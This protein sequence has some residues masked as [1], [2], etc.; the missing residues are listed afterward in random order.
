MENTKF[1]IK[2]NTEKPVRIETHVTTLSTIREVPLEAVAD[3]IQAFQALPGSPLA[4]TFAGLITVYAV[5]D[6]EETTLEDDFPLVELYSGKTKEDPLIIKANGGYKPYPKLAE[7]NGNRNLTEFW[8]S[9]RDLTIPKEGDLK[10]ILSFP[11]IP[12]F[13]P[14][15]FKE[16]YVRQSYKDLFAKILDFEN[17]DLIRMAI[18]GNPGIGKSIFLFYMLWRL[19]SMHTTETVILNRAKDNGMIYVFRNDGCFVTRKVTVICDYLNEK[20]TWYLTDALVIQPGELQAKTILISLPD[21]NQFKTFLKYSATDILRFMPVWSLD[22][23]QA[24]RKLYGMSEKDVI[25]RYCIVGGLPRFVLE[26][27]NQDL[28]TLIKSIKDSYFNGL[29]ELRF[30]DW[31]KIGYYIDR[32]VQFIVDPVNFEDC[33]LQFSSQYVK[34]VAL[35]RL[36][37]TTLRVQN[38]YYIKAE[39]IPTHM[40]NLPWDLCI[41]TVFEMQGGEKRKRQDLDL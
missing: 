7:S 23:L 33:G 31:S 16:M 35:K 29:Q 14:D 38:P 8:N 20:S 5:V 36:G 4:G 21:R 32:V 22:E 13:F 11:V 18:T 2:Y 25:E 12:I 41:D 10:D 30:G 1:Y 3:L 26:K 24:S 28:D 27:K 40:L 15:G 19:A 34:D 6:G 17:E 37:L 9:L 39:R